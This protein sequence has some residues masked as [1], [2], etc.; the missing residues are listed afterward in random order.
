M[1]KLIPGWIHQPGWHCASTV[2]SDVMTFKGQAMSEALCFG[3]GA[4][5][6]FAYL[7]GE[8]FNPTRMTAV[9]SRNLEQNFFAGL[10]LPAVWQTSPSPVEALKQSKDYIDRGI[11]LLIRA[12]IFHL[13][14]YNSKSHFPGHVVC[15]WGYDDKAEEV[16]IADTE[17]PGVQAVPYSSIQKA[18]FSQMPG[19]PIRGD[20]MPVNFSVASPDWPTVIEK[21]L[22]KQ[23]NDL[24]SPEFGGLVPMGFPGMA[25]ARERLPSW[26]SARDW[27]WSAR[28]FYQVIEKRGTGGG[29]FRRLYALFLEEIA[30]M[31]P[32]FKTVAPAEDMFAIAQE[33][34]ELSN[35]MKSLSEKQEPRGFENAAQK[36]GHILNKE[37]EFFA[38]A[39]KELSGEE[40]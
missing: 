40:T 39:E 6:G 17:R 30:K 26:P 22:L 23:V 7:E 14:Y 36:L 35:L 18:R 1:K 27:A 12:D 31:E 9:R 34:T 16:Y 21:A 33:W 15:M 28:W 37:Q 5:L 2:I 8:N 3:L 11:P 38:R 25:R 32:G 4:G 24:K 13:D 10:G 19:Y 20:H 29:A